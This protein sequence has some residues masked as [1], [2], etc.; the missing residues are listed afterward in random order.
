MGLYLCVFDQDDELEGVDVG[1]YDDFGL[2]R[3]RVATT[4]EGDKRGSRFP[5]LMLHLDCDGEWPI[6][7]IPALDK[8]LEQISLEF[9]RSPPIEQDGTWQLQV[10]RQ[11]GLR[12]ESLYACFIDVDGEPLLERLRDLCRVALDAGRPILFQ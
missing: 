7:S 12:P 10:M 6:E 8:E 4:L 9:R 1:S 2:F 11:Q 5:I 3:D